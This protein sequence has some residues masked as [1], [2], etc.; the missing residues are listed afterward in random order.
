MVQFFCLRCEEL[1]NKKGL[2]FSL[3]WEYS[4]LPPKCKNI[5]D[6]YAVGM[7]QIL[8]MIVLKISAL[9]DFNFNESDS[10][11]FNLTFFKLIK[12]MN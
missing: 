12:L 6:Y 7:T 11:D 8:K 9:S 1:F 4:N 3:Q 10:E 2:D 5:A